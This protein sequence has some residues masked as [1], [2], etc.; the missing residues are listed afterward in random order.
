MGE[1]AFVLLQIVKNL[2]VI[3]AEV[4]VKT[5]EVP[6]VPRIDWGELRA[7]R[8]ANQAQKWEGRYA[9]WCEPASCSTVLLTFILK[10]G[11]SLKYGS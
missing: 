2:Y 11:Q 7:N 5:E 4:T 10:F 1:T 8:E 6:S 9:A 3:C